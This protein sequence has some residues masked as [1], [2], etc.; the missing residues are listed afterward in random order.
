M[1]QKEKDFL[2]TC[3]SLAKLAALKGKTLGEQQL[4][5]IAKFL[6][7]ELSYQDINLACGHLA[8]RSS[9]FPDV[10]DFMNLV[11]PMRNIDELIESE[12][13]KLIGIL[14]SGVYDKALFSEYQLD[15]LEVWTWSQLKNMNQATLDKT[16]VSMMWFLKNKLNSDGKTKILLSKKA[17]IE[18]QSGLKELTMGEK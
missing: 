7:S 2:D 18:Y 3:H 10:S 5:L 9:G 17:F 13:G 4:A 8:K 12:I 16:R 1:D 15:L 14:T 6:L 11:C